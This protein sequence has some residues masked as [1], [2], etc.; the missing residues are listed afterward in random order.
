MKH[1]GWMAALLVLLLC[2]GAIALGEEGTEPGTA[3]DWLMD[4]IHLLRQPDLFTW[5]YEDDSIA[6]E[7]DVDDI[8]ET[9]RALGITGVTDEDIRDAKAVISREAAE[10]LIQEA[11][12]ALEASLDAPLEQAEREAL[13]EFYE[14]MYLETSRSWVTLGLLGRA[15]WGTY[16]DDWRWQ[17]TSDTVYSFDAELYGETLYGNFFAGLNAICGGEWVFSDLEEDYT[18]VDLEEGTGVLHLR[19]LLNGQMHQIDAQMACDWFDTG[20]LN[21]IMAMTADSSDGRRLYALY[22]GDQAFILLYNTPQWAKRFTSE[23]GCPLFKA[24]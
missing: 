18:D 17:P 15:G 16:D 12:K 13:E 14:E 19:F 22:D 9:L 21:R 1:A 3:V 7:Q 23:T 11:I 24:L 6:T 5:M 8:A 20:V 4:K 10:E 2:C